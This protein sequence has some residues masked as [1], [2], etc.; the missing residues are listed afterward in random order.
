MQSAKNPYLVLTNINNSKEVYMQS[1]HPNI[2][3]R[4]CK[5]RRKLSKSWQNY[6]RETHDQEVLITSALNWQRRT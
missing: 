3:K 2:R 6:L 1:K 4:P 5:E